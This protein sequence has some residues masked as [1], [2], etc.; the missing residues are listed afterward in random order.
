MAARKDSASASTPHSRLRSSSDPFLDPSSRSSHR[1]PPPPPPK[2]KQSSSSRMPAAVPRS[3]PAARDTHDITEAVRDT[4]TVRG[5]TDY[6]PRAKMSRSQTSSNPPPNSSSRPSGTR[7]SHS[8][9]SGN[10]V[11]KSRSGKSRTSKKGS[12]HADVIDRLDFTGVGPMFHHDGPFDACAPSRNKHR[13]KAPMYAWSGRP[14]DAP[15]ASYGDS[16]YPS[17]H[18]YKAFSNDYE[19]PK[20]KVDAIAEAWGMHEPEPF[21][22]FFAG[23]GSTRPDGD[24]PAS[25]IYNGRESHQS[26]STSRSTATR[27]RGKDSRDT[28]QAQQQQPREARPRGAARRSLVPPPQPIFVPDPTEVAEPAAGS[29][30]GSPNFPKRSKSLMQRIRKMRDAPNVPVSADYDQPPSPSSPSEQSYPNGRPTHRPQNSFLGRFGGQKG[31]QAAT[32]AA[33]DKPEP[34][35]FIETQNNKDLP[36]TPGGGPTPPTAEPLGYFDSTQQNGNATASSG[37]GRKQSL[38]KKVGRVVRGTAR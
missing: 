18:A 2:I 16:A 9:D 23:G 35:V 5:Q 13:N 15:P 11:E 28:Q 17:A 25:S 37:L 21:E 1:T 30:P 8:Q 7:R 10:I 31:N 24:T 12:Q 22:E 14:E 33:S 34:F 4:V 29:S 27:G 20:K 19:P 32:A 38:M 6:S 26:H 36:A 3:A